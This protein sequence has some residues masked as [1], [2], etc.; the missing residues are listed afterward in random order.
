LQAAMKEAH[1]E[2]AATARGPMVDSVWSTQVMKLQ[3]EMAVEILRNICAKCSAT[4]KQQER[5]IADLSGEHQALVTE[6]SSVQAVLA[7]IQKSID[8]SLSNMS[9]DRDDTAA[10][11]S[12]ARELRARNEETLV[13]RTKKVAAL[14]EKELAEQEKLDQMNKTLANERQKLQ[15]FAEWQ[16]GQLEA[17]YTANL[18]EADKLT[19]RIAELN[20]QNLDRKSGCVIC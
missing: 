5:E 4:T 2:Y 7:G 1:E 17:K 14:E 19:S 15:G 20:E 10:A 12:S 8:E 9:D 18:A 13:A 16:G 6:H 11:L 3:P